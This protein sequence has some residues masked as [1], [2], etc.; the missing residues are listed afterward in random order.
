MAVKRKSE[1]S[2]ENIL[3]GWQRIAAFLGQPVTL[4]QRWAKSGMPVRR[5]GR[6]VTAKPEDLTGW[7]AREAHLA[8]PTHIASA[9][10]DLV[11]DLKHS[12]KTRSQKK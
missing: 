1:A 7:L 11:A 4:A 10:G 8:A 9:E 12:L 6:Y 5:E 2:I 3:R